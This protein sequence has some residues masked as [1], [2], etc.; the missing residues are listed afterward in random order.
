MA[1]FAQINSENIVINVLKV[2]DE[3]EHRGEEF[4]NEIGFYG[5]WIQTSY[6]TMHGVHSYNETP[7]RGNYA[8]IGGV[9]DPVLDAFYTKK[10]KEY[11]ILNTT[12]YTWEYPVPVPT[13]IPEGMFP[14]WNEAIMNW[15]I[16]E[17]LNPTIPNVAPTDPGVLPTHH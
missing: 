6:N 11:M 1:H 8:R 13:E 4:L 12:T 5:K 2:S 7:L 10:P 14:K 17:I 15:E 9:Y 3:Q 16:V